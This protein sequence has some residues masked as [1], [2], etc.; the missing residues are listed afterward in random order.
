VAV[1]TTVFKITPFSSFPSFIS[2][3]L[4]EPSLATK[5]SAKTCSGEININKHFKKLLRETVLP[6]TLIK[7][8]QQDA[9]PQNKTS[10]FHIS[11]AH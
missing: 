7:Y 8:A 5:A 6:I 3:L 4:E 1:C 2:R 11:L 9:E 10:Q